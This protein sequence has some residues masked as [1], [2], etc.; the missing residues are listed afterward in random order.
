MDQLAYDNILKAGHLLHQT[1]I[2]FGR[3]LSSK[4]Y[5]AYITALEADSVATTEFVYVVIRELRRLEESHL[6]TRG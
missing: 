4:D 1:G 3:H 5:D 6:Q 2:T